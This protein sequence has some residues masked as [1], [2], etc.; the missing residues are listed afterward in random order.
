MSLNC[1]VSDAIILILTNSNIYSITSICNTTNFDLF[2]YQLS[3][4]NE[5]NWNN[6][7]KK[8]I[9]CQESDLCSRWHQ[10]GMM[11]FVMMNLILNYVIMTVL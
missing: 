5:N 10:N 7:F 8:N 11:V 3:L 4:I 9:Y 6:I 1:N 2:E